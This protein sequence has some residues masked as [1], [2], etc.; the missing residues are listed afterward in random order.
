MSQKRRKFK[1]P[2]GDRRYKTMF[3]IATE[4]EKTEPQYFGMFNSDNTVIH[5]KC[6][7]GKHGSSPLQVLGRMRKHLKESNLRKKDEA[8]LVVDRDQWTEDQLNQ[9]YNWSTNNDSHGFSLSNPNFEYWLLLHFENGH[10][11][12]TASGCSIRLNRY[13][14]EY[15]KGIDTDKLK[16]NVQHA[17]NRA[18]QKDRPPCK[19]WPT[20]TGTTVYRLVEKIMALLK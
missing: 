1:R 12:S 14:P 8:W 18:K 4:G 7:K 5:V 16:H 6:L 17:V 3:I 13:L 15:D 9:L 11:V 20:T 2:L 19:K 10:G